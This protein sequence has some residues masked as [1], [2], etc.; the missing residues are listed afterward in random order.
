MGNVFFL[1]EKSLHILESEIEGMSFDTWIKEIKPVADLTDALYFEVSNDFHKRILEQRYFDAIFNAIKQAAADVGFTAPFKDLTPV[2]IT[3]EEYA[4][5]K[6]NSVQD[7]TPDL[8]NYSLNPNYTFESFVVGSNNNFAHAASIAVAEN[9]GS[10]YNPLFIYGGTGL[11]KT[12]LM[13]AI[14]NYASS[15]F[16][17]KKVM[18]V[19]SETFL[20]ELIGAIATTQD[21]QDFMKHKYRREAQEQFRN[22]YR[23]AD[24]LLIDDIQF[25]S[26]K[27]GFQEEFFH[28]FNDLYQ[29]N[30]QIVISS[31]KPPKEIA[32]LEDRLRSRF[33]WGL[34]A[35]I[36]EPDFETKV[37][38]L[39]KKVEEMRSRGLLNFHID[40]SILH[41]IA[42]KSTSDIRQLE[43]ALQKV[44]AYTSLLNINTVNVQIAEEALKNYFFAAKTKRITP[45]IIIETVCSYFD[46][47]DEDIKGK[48][49][50]RE[51]SYPRQMAMYLIR[52]M[53]DCSLLKIGEIF[54]GKDHT[55]V[56]HAIDKIKTQIDEDVETEKVINDLVD[57]IK[58]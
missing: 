51:I 24:V 40:N 49:K 44:I 52:S 46:I 25:I 4:L 17:D 11:G 38:I 32:H 5:V 50:N 10:K 26:G 29:S 45:Q 33:E 41:F 53:T 20:N 48:K 42:T 22:K 34:I 8:I 15:Q 47:S 6:V 35:D 14:G 21:V 57:K 2:F 27:Y 56:M 54:G 19:K 30:K 31:D 39:M 7:S 37:A 36:Q 18:Y 3:K 12:H 55:T 1:W 43:G 9:P 16:K 58:K 28:T 13:H 23:G